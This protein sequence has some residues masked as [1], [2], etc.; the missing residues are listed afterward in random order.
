MRCAECDTLVSLFVLP[1]RNCVL[2]SDHTPYCEQ[3]TLRM[4]IGLHHQVINS[5]RVCS[6]HLSPA[7]I[8]LVLTSFLEF[9]FCSAARRLC[10][11]VSALTHPLSISLLACTYSKFIATLSSIKSSSIVGS[12]YLNNIKPSCIHGRVAHNDLIHYP[13]LDWR[14]KNNELLIASIGYDDQLSKKMRN[15]I[16]L[17]YTTFDEAVLTRWW[18]KRDVLSKFCSAKIYP[19]D[20]SNLEL[21]CILCLYL[22]FS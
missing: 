21:I 6:L 1:L 16:Y 4:V 20:E 7:K 10:C 3:W 9:F 22:R 13:V 17:G 14:V 2:S 8:L 15:T 19:S 18:L 12:Q 11:S 5:S